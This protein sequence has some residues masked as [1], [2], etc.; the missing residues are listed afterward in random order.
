MEKAPE[1]HQGDRT[2]DWGRF[3]KSRYKKELG[4]ISRL[5]SRTSGRCLS[6]T[7]R[8]S[9]SGKRVSPLPMNLWRTPG[10]V[11]EDVWD[12]I[13]NNQLIRTKDGKEPKG[14]NIRFTNLPK[15]TAIREIR[16]DD[17]NKF[18][19]VEGILRKTTEVRPRIVE[20]VFK[21]PGRPLHQK[22]PEIREVH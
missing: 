18:V 22:N 9:G 21:L 15:K 20:A 8:S 16:S 3:L 19:S 14:I 6:I 1:L 17:I 12:A 2:E 4:E 11:L 7:G 5:V 13:K 10:K